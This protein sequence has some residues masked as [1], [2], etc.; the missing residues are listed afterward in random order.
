MDL[1]IALNTPVFTD[2][3]KKYILCY[4][5]DVNIKYF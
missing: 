5:W 1:M 2:G 4:S 3:N